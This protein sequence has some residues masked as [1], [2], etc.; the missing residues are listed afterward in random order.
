[1]FSTWCQADLVLWNA[2]YIDISI[3]KIFSHSSRCNITERD[4]QGCLPHILCHTRLL[5]FS[6]S[7]SAKSSCT[8]CRYFSEQVV[9]YIVTITK[10]CEPIRATR[11]PTIWTCA[12]HTSL[13]QRKVSRISITTHPVQQGFVVQK[14][15]ETRRLRG[16]LEIGA[17]H[18]EIYYFAL[19]T[20][21]TVFSHSC[22]KRF[23][24]R[25]EFNL[26]CKIKKLTLYIK[27]FD[28]RIFLY[29]RIFFFFFFN[30]FFNDK[31]FY[32][33]GSHMHTQIKRQEKQIVI[34]LINN[35]LDFSLFCYFLILIT[36]I[37]IH[38]SN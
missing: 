6:V 4:I 9:I 7:Y 18:L 15:A 3:L 36:F 2:I 26:F 12:E 20:I 38:A 13:G 37:I 27:R 1:M 11:P 10:S 34:Y 28:T 21:C 14:C 19:E 33:S 25:R 24:P 17:D 31:Y 16:S 35:Y 32:L 5:F 22:K 8:N 23:H 29:I 30:I